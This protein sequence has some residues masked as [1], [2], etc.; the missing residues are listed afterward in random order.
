MQNMVNTQ[1]SPQDEVSYLFSVLCS[2]APNVN[3]FY[4]CKSEFCSFIFM[5][6][7]FI[8]CCNFSR[9]LMTRWAQVK[10][11]YHRQPWDS[12]LNH[13]THACMHLT[14]VTILLNECFC[15]FYVVIFI[16]FQ[17]MDWSND[18]AGSWPYFPVNKILTK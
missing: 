1:K 16:A 18:N 12:Q 17:C 3:H 11:E 8:K 10:I 9:I 2:L 13:K 7:S 15:C 5:K 4:V 6:I 14:I